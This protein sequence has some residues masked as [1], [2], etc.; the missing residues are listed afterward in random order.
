MGRPKRKTSLE[1][2]YFHGE[3]VEESNAELC[4][5]QQ[6]PMPAR[7]ANCPYKHELWTFIC[8][9][10]EK[11][12]CLSTTYTLLISE[13]CEVCHTMYVCRQ[14]LDEEGM[15]IERFS[16]EGS[17]LGSSPSP[18][19]AIVSRQQPVLIKLLE[20]TGMSPRDITYLV[21]PE[22]TS[23]ATIEVIAE[24]KKGITYFRT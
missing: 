4:T 16:D 11:R 5:M 6:M 20:K 21:N 17:Y 2:Y 22:A 3:D 12:K 9:D 18:Y 10:M 19:V 13:I 1:R 24:E 8:A 15:I 14:K 7:I 23:A